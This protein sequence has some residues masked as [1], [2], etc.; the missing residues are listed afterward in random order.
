MGVSDSG[1]A[2]REGG[3]RGR[4]GEQIRTA[5]LRRTVHQVVALKG[6][7]ILHGLAFELQEHIAAEALLQLQLGSSISNAVISG[8]IHRDGGASKVAHKQLQTG[9]ALV[10]SLTP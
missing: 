3:V 6:P 5:H 1:T 9:G 8:A 7:A 10:S 2:G 4:E